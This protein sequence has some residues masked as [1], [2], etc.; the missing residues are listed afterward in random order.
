MMAKKKA[1]ALHLSF[2]GKSYPYIPGDITARMRRQVRQVTGIPVL[3][4]E[5]AMSD[6]ESIDLDM[7]LVMFY[8]GALL[9]GDDPNF[10][11][12]LDEVTQDNPITAEYREVEDDPET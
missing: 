8:A 9:A 3:Q 11:A 4:A 5:R 10:E 7:A 2:D 12:L 1:T 6:R